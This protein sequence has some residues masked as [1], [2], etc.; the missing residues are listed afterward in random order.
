MVPF[1]KCIHEC[2]ISNDTDPNKISLLFQEKSDIE[3]KN[4]MGYASWYS[5]ATQRAR[6]SNL[7]LLSQNTGCPRIKLTSCTQFYKALKEQ[8]RLGLQCQ[9]PLRSYPLTLDT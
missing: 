3:E 9:T 2:H 1:S 7:A 8:T 5:L 4:I 6:F